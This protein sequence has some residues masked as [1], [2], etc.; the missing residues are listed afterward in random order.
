[1]YS[2]LQLYFVSKLDWFI[3]GELC[4]VCHRHVLPTVFLVSRLD[5]VIVGEM[6]D[7]CYR[8]VLSTVSCVKAGLL[9]SG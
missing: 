3:V 6:C 1:M 2:L 8:H 7:V 9:H 4:A 5:W